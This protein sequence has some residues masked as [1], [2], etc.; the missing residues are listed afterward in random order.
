MIPDKEKCAHDL[1]I[2]YM[3]AEIKNGLIDTPYGDDMH[4]FVSLYFSHYDKII[5]ILET[6]Y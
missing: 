3:Q 5:N 1:A 2:L 6:D 4:D